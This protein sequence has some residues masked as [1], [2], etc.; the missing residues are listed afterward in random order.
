[1][2]DF[3]PLTGSLDESLDERSY[4]EWVRDQGLDV[5]IKG[6]KKIKPT[7]INRSAKRARNRMKCDVNVT[8]T[9]MSFS[10][11]AH[12]RM[13]THILIGTG[14]LDGQGVVLI[15]PA[16]ATDTRAYKPTPIHTKTRYQLLSE[17][18]MSVVLPICPLGKYRLVA[19]KGGFYLAPEEGRKCESP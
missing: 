15:R 19:I 18:V 6:P 9:G 3:R 16:K 5:E 8:K 14:E 12:A 17:R 7:W 11:T 13:G 2:A 10:L 4:Q 1:M